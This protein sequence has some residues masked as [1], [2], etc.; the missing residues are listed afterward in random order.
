MR[1]DWFQSCFHYL[2]GL[3]HQR[4]LVLAG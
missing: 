4:D 1:E 3:K 2:S